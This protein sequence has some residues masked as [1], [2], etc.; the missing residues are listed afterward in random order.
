MGLCGE[1]VVAD[2]RIQLF[3]AKGDFME[4]LYEEPKGSKC[5]GR[6]G[7][8]VIDADNKILASKTEQRGRNY[9][10]LLSLNDRNLNNII[11]SNECKLKRPSGIAVTSDQH[12]IVVDLGNN[13]IKKYKYW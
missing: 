10:Q 6:Y 7:G 3:S 1:I 9:I 8:I 11:D 5:K 13:C 12:V 4:I 2:T